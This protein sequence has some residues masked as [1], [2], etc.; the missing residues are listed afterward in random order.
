MKTDISNSFQKNNSQFRYS[1]AAVLLVIIVFIFNSIVHYPSNVL[2]FDVFGYYLYLPQFFIYNHPENSNLDTLHHINETYKNTTTLYQLVNIDENTNVFKYSMGMALLYLPFFLIGHFWASFSAFPADGFSFP[3]QA[4]IHC[5]S[6]FYVLIGVWMLRKILLHYFSDKITAI[7]VISI[8]FGTNFYFH[9]VFY[10]QETMS[11]SYL[12]TL[13]TLIIWYTIKWHQN[14]QK[15]H[16]FLL[17]L[18]CGF[19]ILARPSEIICLLIPFFFGI[20]NKRD[21]MDKLQLIK[22]Y[23]FNFLVFFLIMFLIGSLQFIYWKI[24]TGHFLFDSY[25]ANNGEGFEFLR[26]YT[27]KVLFSFRKGWLLYTP[28]MIFAIL[29]FWFL[30]KYYK[31]IFVVFFLYFLVNLYIVSSWSCWWYAE[32]FG[33]RALIPSYV[34]LSFSLAAFL[35]YFFER[36]KN[37]YSIIFGVFLIAFI[38][39][40]QFQTW[41]F[42]KGILKSERMTK[43]Y[44]KAAFL[45][46]TYDENWEKLLLVNRNFDKGEKFEN[47]QEYILTKTY[48]LKDEKGNYQEQLLPEN[49]YSHF[50]EMPY[51]ELTD[52]DHVW[53]KA[54]ANVKAEDSASEYYLSMFFSYKGKAYKY[55]N[56][57]SSEV[58]VDSIG[59]K[60]LTLEYL[61]PEVRNKKDKVRV[62]I[63]NRNHQKLLLN[64]LYFEVYEKKP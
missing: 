9:S 7:V 12:F 42:V 27:L 17:A 13:Y 44:Y 26:P 16:L 20:K 51:N 31:Q 24:Y 3:Y 6:V 18:F 59:N 25:A 52:K 49:E 14:H 22:T 60:T 4:A 19:T 1:F 36:K 8:F 64:K 38:T 29:G 23:K 40:N 58:A 35:E 54:Y 2:C 43:E 61:S 32:S 15:K 11:H 55:A 10:G 30:Y 28:I 62:Y 39:L 33:Q 53:I 5:G 45:K 21:L 57:I 56:K 50:V 37:F 41:Q 48:Y 47:E 63:W 46:T 34:V